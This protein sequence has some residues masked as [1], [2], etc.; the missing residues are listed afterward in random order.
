MCLDEENGNEDLDCHKDKNVVIVA[1]D[2]V[3]E[4]NSYKEHFG[5][6]NYYNIFWCFYTLANIPSDCQNNVFA[7]FID[8]Q[9][10]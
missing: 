7:L 9:S 4:L 6:K 5:F 8:E 1:G 3:R 10:M 2:Q